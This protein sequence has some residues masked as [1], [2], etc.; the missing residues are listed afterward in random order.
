MQVCADSHFVRACS[1]M[2]RKPNANFTRFSLLRAY[3]VL[4]FRRSETVCISLR[5]VA[6]QTVSRSKEFVYCA[7]YLAAPTKVELQTRT[8]YSFYLG[9][10]MGWERTLVCLGIKLSFAFR[11]FRITCRLRIRRDKSHSTNKSV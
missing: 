10:D 1:T 8:R 9:F 3:L 6:K 11:S 7:F 5:F 4:T 2:C